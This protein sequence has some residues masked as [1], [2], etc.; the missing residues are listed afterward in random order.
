M[1]LEVYE[2]ECRGIGQNVSKVDWLA[3][4]L[5]RLCRDA[6]ALG[7]DVVC[8]ANGSLYL[9]DAHPPTSTSEEYVLARVG[10]RNIYRRK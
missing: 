5:H 3:S 2:K 7:L 9:R 10:F 1:S 4:R 8:D 6:D